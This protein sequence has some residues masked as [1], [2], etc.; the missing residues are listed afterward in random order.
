LNLTTEVGKIALIFDGLFLLTIGY[1]IF[2]S[3]FLPRLLGALV[4]L[5][6]LA[7]LTFLAPPLANDLST[8]VEVVG[9]LAE[10]PLMLWL[11]VMGVTHSGGT[12]LAG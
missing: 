10:A 3:T 6:G 5:A 9:A 4:A 11:L 12:E 7:W 8:Y 1:L 2:Q